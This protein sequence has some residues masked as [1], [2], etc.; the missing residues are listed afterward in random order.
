MTLT[1]LRYVVA[2]ARERHF[3]RAAEACFVSQPTLS[4]GIKKLEEELGVAIFERGSNEISLTHVG[5]QIVAQ[6]ALILEE[7]SSIKTI[8]QQSGDPLGHPLRLGAI[9]T[10]GPY[11]LPQIIPILRKNAPDMQLIIQ[12]SYTGDL[13]EQLK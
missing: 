2:V 11:L 8:A 5:E 1:E 4:V 12:E 6:A 7:A 13:R 10:V 9:Y 3:G